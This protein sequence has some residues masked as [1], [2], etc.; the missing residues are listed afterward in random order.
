MNKHTAISP[1]GTV[2][3]RNSKTN[4]YGVCVFSKN[5][6]GVW[7]LVGWS[8][9]MATAQKLVNSMKSTAKRYASCGDFTL[10]VAFVETEVK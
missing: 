1:N 9:N 6:D 2:V 7:V 5:I 4:V 3:T 8:R 10:E